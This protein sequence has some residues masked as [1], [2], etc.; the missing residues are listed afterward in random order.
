[1]HFPTIDW[2]E[3]W[4]ATLMP[5]GL[6]LLAAIAIWVIGGWLIRAVIA[7]MTRAMQ[8]QG[9]DPTLKR[10]AQSFLRVALK[11]ALFL[12]ILGFLGV[13]TT[14]FAALMAA[15]GVA[16]GAAWSGLLANFAAGVFLVVLRPFKVG[17]SILVN[18][19]TGTVREIGLFGTT[20]DTADGARVLIGNNRVFMDNIVN[21]SVNP[22][23][24]VDL[25]CQL[26]HGVDAQQAM[27]ALR[28]RVGALPMVR[29]EPPMLV[30]IA[31]YGP[32]GLT[33]AVRPHCANA[34]YWPLFYAGN[35]AIAELVQQQGWP[36][37][38]TVTATR[39][40]EAPAD[41]TDP[42]RARG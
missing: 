16:I 29:S 17:D 28:A 35:K 25:L 34:D 3:L 1:M 13:E 12:G 4:R 8:A 18:T 32:T 10:Y 24:R 42:S 22:T 23:R 19:V 2:N 36:A 21:Y 31:G 15:A 37:P 6:K 39:T 14:S 38:E 7:A 33:I 30:E 27:D 40:I 26:G 5:A 9:V 20:L 11:F 41:P